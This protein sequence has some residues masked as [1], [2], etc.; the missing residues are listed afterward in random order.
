MGRASRWLP[1]AAIVTVLALVNVAS[2][3]LI[4]H[5]WYVPFAV[6]SALV[7]LAFARLVDRRTWDDLGLA[8]ANLRRGAAWG[9]AL[10]GV[11]LV[12]YLIG[13]FIPGT[14]DLFRDERVHGWSFGRT[15]DA[16]FI[17]VPLGTVLLEEV[18]FRSVLPAM[19]GARTTRRTA[20]GVS[21]ALFGLWHILPAMGFD[22]VNSVTRDT[23]GTQ[24]GWVTVVSA[25]VST[26]LVGIWFWWLR[27][28]SGSLL[29]PMAL[30]WATNALGY[31]F[32]YWA[33]HW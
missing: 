20:I 3:R 31:G 12:A 19:L 1:I 25:V 30:H 32:A 16:V 28:R 13:I 11:V 8:R 21:A 9:G 33:W 17:R 5:R 22:K 29:T 18:A 2:N 24:P 10:I 26:A 6:A 23:L 15:L 27:H 4:A 7:T 14:R